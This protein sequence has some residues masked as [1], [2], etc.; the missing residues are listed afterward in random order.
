[1]EVTF[2]KVSV[3]DM[4]VIQQMYRQSFEPIYLRYRDDETD[5]YLESLSSLQKKAR[6]IGSEYFFCDIKGVR[7]GMIRVI[8]DHSTK[9]ARISPMCVLPEFQG[10]GFAQATLIE[11]EQQFSDIKTWYLDTIAEEPKL[12]YLYK[13]AG[14]QLVID[15][16]KEIKPGMNLA[17]FI[18]QI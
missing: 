9:E 18:K 15:Q 13:K 5:P 16:H 12:M 10:K 3:E 17:Y 4:P 7:I 2:V 6:R 14:Y 8:S 1:M 11:I